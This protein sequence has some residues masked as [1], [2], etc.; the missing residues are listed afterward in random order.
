M[1]NPGNK[2][3]SCGPSRAPSAS[4]CLEKHGKQEIKQ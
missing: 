3:I 1:L 4:L 2:A